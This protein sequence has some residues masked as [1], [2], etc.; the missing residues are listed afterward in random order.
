MNTDSMLALSE[1]FEV[2]LVFFGVLTFFVSILTF[3]D[4]F[5][6]IWR[7]PPPIKSAWAGE[8]TS[9]ADLRAMLLADGGVESNVQF[10]AE[11]GFNDPDALPFIDDF[12]EFADSV[13]YDA[14][15]TDA[16]ISTD[17][18][19]PRHADIIADILALNEAIRAR[20]GSE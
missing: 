9:T 15:P 19:T 8:E 7:G 14:V 13:V 4:S 16:I 5:C 3:V 6:K 20:T 10:T 18:D 12:D 1:L 2:A 11:G 17:W